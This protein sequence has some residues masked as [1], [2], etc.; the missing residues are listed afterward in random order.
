MQSTRDSRSTV[1]YMAMVY[2]SQDLGITR[3]NGSTAKSRASASTMVPM[4]MPTPA[5]GLK[6]SDMGMELKECPEI[7]A[8]TRVTSSMVVSKG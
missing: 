5:N 3:A 8:S 6:I 2:M 1:N 4:E 7:A